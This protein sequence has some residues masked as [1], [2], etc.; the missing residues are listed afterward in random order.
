MLQA[1]EALEEKCLKSACYYQVI[2]SYN[3]KVSMTI[4]GKRLCLFHIGQALVTGF[5]AEAQTA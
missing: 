5:T 4:K 1:L 2:M 3:S